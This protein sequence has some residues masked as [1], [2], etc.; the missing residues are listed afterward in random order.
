MFRYAFHCWAC[1][2]TK[3]YLLQALDELNGTGSICRGKWTDEVSGCDLS[4]AK[5]FRMITV[6]CGKGRHDFFCPLRRNENIY[7]STDCCC[8]TPPKMLECWPETSSVESED[9]SWLET[10]SWQSKLNM[11]SVLFPPQMLLNMLNSTSIWVVFN[12]PSSAVFVLLC[13]LLW[14]TPRFQSGLV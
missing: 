12:N 8:V 14:L 13:H 4:R 3:C 1:P 10:L 5:L 2:V 6:V 9:V 7:K 11:L